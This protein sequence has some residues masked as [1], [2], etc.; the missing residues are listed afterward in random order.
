MVKPAPRHRK[1]V[2]INCAYC[3]GGSLFEVRDN[4]I[5]LEVWCYFVQFLLNCLVEIGRF[6][7]RQC[8]EYWKRVVDVCHKHGEQLIVQPWYYAGTNMNIIRHDQLMF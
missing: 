1:V 2:S 5:L 3:S 6:P 8:V 7:G 4:L